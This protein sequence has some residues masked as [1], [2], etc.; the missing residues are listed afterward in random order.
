MK[1]VDPY[2]KFGPKKLNSPSTLNKLRKK[3][4]P[5]VHGDFDINDLPE[6]ESQVHLGKK[7]QIVEDNKVR[8]SDRSEIE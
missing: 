7:V 4:E 3:S 8:L 6:I 5:Y 1:I 2:E